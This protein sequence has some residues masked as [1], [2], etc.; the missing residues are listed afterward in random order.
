MEINS[1]NPEEAIIWLMI[2][3]LMLLVC[4]VSYLVTDRFKKLKRYIVVSSLMV[5]FFCTSI[6]GLSIFVPNK[7]MII[8]N[9]L[10]EIVHVNQGS[11][12]AI[13]R[14][15]EILENCKIVSF[16]KGIIDKIF[17][18]FNPISVNPKVREISYS[19]ELMSIESPEEALNRLKFEKEVRPLKDHLKF[20]LYEFHEKHGKEIAEFYNPVNEKQQQKFSS[21]LKDFISPHLEKTGVEISNVRFNL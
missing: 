17:M 10:Q 12:F 8:S 15:N 14:N 18:S 6:L 21:L 16:K 1:F 5:V 4:L 9:D 20:W 13:F 19:V 2:C 3:I 11:V 7:S